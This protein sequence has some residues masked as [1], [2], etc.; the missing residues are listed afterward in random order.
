MVK[1]QKK[2]KESKEK[3]KKDLDKRIL[4]SLEEIISKKD[5]GKKVSVKQEPTAPSINNVDI[6]EPIKYQRRS[7]STP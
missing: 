3:P 6:G 7:S 5:K 4:D 2:R 1:N